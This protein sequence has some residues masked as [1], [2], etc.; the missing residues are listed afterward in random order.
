MLTAKEKGLSI[1]ATLAVLGRALKKVGLKAGVLTRITTHAIR[2]GAIR[3][4][5]HIKTSMVG[6]EEAATALCRTQ[7][8]DNVRRHNADVYWP[9]PTYSIQYEG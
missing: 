9:C 1:A 8:A 7:Q 2:R 5:A 6:V 4:I 3:D